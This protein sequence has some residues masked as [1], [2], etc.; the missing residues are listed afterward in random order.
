MTAD[1]IDMPTCNATCPR[2]LHPVGGVRI[3][4]QEVTAVTP[5]RP[6]MPMTC[7]LLLRLDERAPRE[8]PASRLAR[9]VRS[10]RL[11]LG[12]RGARKQAKSGSPDRDLDV[13]TSAANRVS[14]LLGFLRCLG[15]RGALEPPCG[16][17]PDRTPPPQGLV[18]PSAQERGDALARDAEALGDLLHRHAFVVERLRLGPADVRATGIERCGVL[19]EQLND[20]GPSSL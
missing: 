7:W 6:D 14:S 1:G 5:R 8:R 12:L 2:P 16:Y 4:R 15:W 10:G 11:A 20:E 9:F 17:R 3:A 18:A 13:L 19:G